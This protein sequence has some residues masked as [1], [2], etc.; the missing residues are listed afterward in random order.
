MTPTT[1]CQ[2]KND[3]T[4]PADGDVRLSDGHEGLL[5][6]YYAGMWGTVCDDYWTSTNAIVVCRQLGYNTV[7]ASDYSSGSTHTG[8]I[9]LDNVQCVSTECRI[10]LCVHNGWG[11]EDCNHHEDVFIRCGDPMTT[12]APTQ[13]T[14]AYKHA[15]GG[16]DG[17]N[18]CHECTDDC[19]HYASLSRHAT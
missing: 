17:T 8:T 10:E 9:W 5:E 7:V 13:P 4:N 16:D 19:T 14:H 15:D 3:P 12:S 1:I 18:Y 2:R 6:V 11:D